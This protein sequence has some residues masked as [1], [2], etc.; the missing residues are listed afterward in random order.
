MG[1]KT[2]SLQP[3]VTAT[4]IIVHT[5]ASGATQ[6]RR[7]PVD[8]LAE[9]MVGS[10]PV[11]QALVASSTG[12]VQALS[13]AQLSA[14][15]GSRFGQ[16]GRCIGGATT[17]HTDPVTGLTVIDQGEYL[18]ST[19]P[20]GWRRAGDL[21][22]ALASDAEAVAGAVAN[23]GVPPTGVKAAFDS[24]IATAPEALTTAPTEKVLSAK[25]DAIVATLKAS[26]AL[27]QLDALG[28]Q[29][30]Q[31]YG[32]SLASVVP[33]VVDQARR[34]LL[35]MDANTG[36]FH[37]RFDISEELNRYMR[38]LG[39]ATEGVQTYSGAGPIFPIVVDAAN[40]ALIYF[41]AG[42]GKIYIPE[43]DTS[44][45]A[46]GSSS[47]GARPR[48][49]LAAEV[50]LPLVSSAIRFGFLSYGQSLAI[51]AQ[52]QPP[53]STTQPFNNLTFG[54]GPKTTLTG[55]GFGG[56]NTS[57]MNTEKA[58]V[59][60]SLSPDAVTG[61]G[62]T[63]CSGTVNGAVELASQEASID[64]ATF[65]FFASA[66]G[67]G[68]ESINQLIKSAS[69]DTAEIPSA[70]Q[71][72]YRNF[73]DHVT[74]AKDLA[75]AAGKTYVVAAISWMQGE[76]DTA[77]GKT[78][79]KGLLNTLINDMQADV[80]AIT[81]QAIKPHVIVYQQGSGL[82]S[83]TRG[84]ALAQWELSV[85]RP[86]VWL[87]TPLYFLEPAA[88]GIHAVN[89]SYHYIGR[90]YARVLKSILV[91]RLKPLQLN[92]KGATLS[93]SVLRLRMDVPML[94]LVFDT[95]TLGAVQDRGFRVVSDAGVATISTI[96]IEGADI[97]ITLSGTAPTTNVKLRYGLDYAPA[98]HPS[99]KLFNS[100]GAG[101]LRDS[102]PDRF[103]KGGTQRLL[104][105]WC[106][107][108][109]INVYKAES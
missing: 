72:Y 35:W 102:S 16:P 26:S 22:G 8:K 99:G 75:T 65:I 46:G 1:T 87:G 71:N 83:G 31:G 19:S 43:L 79:Y 48:E 33:L 37:G 70:T 78:T 27:R 7:I 62:E 100:A 92:P 59:E 80:M 42:T 36:E 84:P 23:K 41:N 101:N 3:A 29:G 9:Q 61:R 30:L 66:C 13:W 64:P 58:L 25:A 88:D 45:F 85:E 20:A 106:P 49:A 107:S 54:S 77:M 57:A 86:D 73:L 53:I 2:T 6:V 4:E 10:G 11:S 15:A 82:A 5:S 17:T 32:G 47:G 12:L 76:A 60:D 93:G 67:K 34:A 109:E 69:P 38:S 44:G 63:V 98:S 28:S 68:G 95:A 74:K 81:G 14:T 24:R 21:L 51:G 94:P 56:Q 91:D 50:T 18:W 104:P 108:F 90:A 97:V 52:G 105:F 39:A 96:T 89:T 103:V 55:N 40:R